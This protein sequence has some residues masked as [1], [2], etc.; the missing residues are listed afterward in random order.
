[1]PWNPL[2]ANLS[3]RLVLVAVIVSVMPAPAAA[4]LTKK[5][6]V[7]DFENLAALYAKRYA[8]YAWK[9]ELFGFDLFDLQPWLTRIRQSRDDLTFL[10]ILHQYVASLHD[11]HT[12]FTTPSSFGTEPRIL[13]RYL[14]RPRGDR[15][16]QPH[17]PAA[18]A[19]SVRDRGHPGVRGRRAERGVDRVFLTVPEEC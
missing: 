19:V 13:G 8:P 12:F 6:K 1:M 5:Q 3:R 16:N 17:A 18:G 2:L 15:G 4:Q 7:H 11:T 10:E 14:R 9:K